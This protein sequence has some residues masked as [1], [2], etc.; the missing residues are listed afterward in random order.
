MKLLISILLLMAAQI[1]WAQKTYV[2]EVGDLHV[3]SSNFTTNDFNSIATYINSHTNDA[4]VVGS[5]LLIPGDLYEQDTN[6]INGGRFGNG[7]TNLVFLTNW[8]QQ[9][10]NNG[11][12]V[13]SCNGNHDADYTNIS[14]SGVAGPWACNNLALL[15]TNVF[16]NSFFTQQKGFWTNAAPNDSHNVVMF[17]TNGIEKF[18]FCTLYWANTNNYASADLSV[19]YLSQIQW[20]TNIAGTFLDHN[21]IV[22]AHYF[23]SARMLCESNCFFGNGRYDDLGLADE[24]FKDGVLQ[25]PNFMAFRGGHT[26]PLISGHTT[27]TAKNGHT[28]DAACWNTQ[29][30]YHDGTNIYGGQV[31]RVCTLDNSIRAMTVNTYSFD[32][33]AMLT[34]FDPR[35]SVDS[36]YLSSSHYGNPN[37]YRNFVWSWNVPYAT[38]TRYTIFNFLNPH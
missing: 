12:M 28:I 29:N 3:G 11:I 2:Y 33:G 32:N 15:W 37:I 20:L 1:T 8:C 36:Q 16:P 18:A 27:Y 23:V 31:L 38:P 13:I 6:G 10:V 35:Y 34:N 25:W 22:L 5:I 4:G 19:L 9:F 14:S 7:L 21:I 30:G 17:Y 24:P 26:Q